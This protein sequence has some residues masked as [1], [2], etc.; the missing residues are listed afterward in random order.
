MK[1]LCMKKSQFYNIHYLIDVINLYL[2]NICVDKINL[3]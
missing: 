3:K 2:L 1:T